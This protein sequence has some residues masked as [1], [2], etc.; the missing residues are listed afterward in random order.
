MQLETQRTTNA[1]S[2]LQYFF[3][4]LSSNL[5]SVNILPTRNTKKAIYSCDKKN[6]QQK[7]FKVN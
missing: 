2:Q 1:T 6:H 3:S 7:S 5:D 4:E